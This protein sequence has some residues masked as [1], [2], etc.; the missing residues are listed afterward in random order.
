MA[1]HLRVVAERPDVVG[2]FQRHG[3]FRRVRA[4]VGMLGLL[5]RN[6]LR[7]VILL[8]IGQADRVRKLHPLFLA[9]IRIPPVVPREADFA[10]SKLARLSPDRLG[11]VEVGVRLRVRRDVAG[12]RGGLDERRVHLLVLDAPLRERGG[13]LGPQPLPVGGVLHEVRFERV[14]AAVERYVTLTHRRARLGHEVFGNRYLDVGVTQPIAGAL[15]DMV[16]LL[17]RAHDGSCGD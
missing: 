8:L 3:P 15:D 5:A 11:R 1:V 17:H 9:G 6:L 2:K 16:D 7:T 4:E 13:V 14:L 12:H 10:E